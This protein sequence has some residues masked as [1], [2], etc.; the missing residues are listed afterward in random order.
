VDE[1]A[2][3]I[4]CTSPGTIIIQK[5]TDPEGVTT[6]FEFTT[7][8]SSNFFLADGE[9]NNSG[10]LPPDTYSV[11]ENIPAGWAL[12]SA[13]C[14]DGSSP[15][16]IDLDADETVTCTFTNNKIFYTLS[17]GATVN[18]TITLNPPGGTYSGD[19]VVEVK[20]TPAEGYEFK[21]W[22][23]DLSGI[24]NPESITMDSN[25]T[26]T[27]T[28]NELSCL[29]LHTRFDDSEPLSPG[30]TYYT[31]RSYTLTSV[32]EQYDGLYMIR[33]PYIESNRTDASDYLTFE[34][35]QD[36]VVYVAI[37]RRVTDPPDWMDGFDNTG[38]RIDT[39]LRGQKYLKVHSHE[40]SAGD[41]INFGANQAPGFSGGTAGN[42]IVFVDI[43]DGPPV[44]NVQPADVTVAAGQ[45]ATFSIA[46]TGFLP[47]HYL[48]TL[49]GSS[50][51]DDSPS[52]TIPNVQLSEK[53]GQV[54]CAVSDAFERDT[55]SRVAKLTVLLPKGAACTQNSECASNKCKGKSGNM[56]CK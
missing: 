34:M 11:S 6:S 25:K 8:Y 45:D 29:P 33:T 49:N 40:F 1:G 24:I 56:T 27:A 48:W 7:D 30:T 23:G 26:V 54:V 46:A 16:E 4:S 21:Q 47:L 28:F 50:V 51:G 55:W 18:G 5:Q 19:T 12:F 39:S 35:P 20:A 22:S 44:I 14:D 36:G 53:P 9:T 43:A 41:C 38:D 52:I 37:D 31:D 15:S 10:N 13:I 42:Y 2:G 17:L 3:D 32:P